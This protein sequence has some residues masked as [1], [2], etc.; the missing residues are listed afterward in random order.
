MPNFRSPL[1]CLLGFVALFCMGLPSLAAPPDA[2][3]WAMYNHDVAGWR[4]NAAEKSLSP[5]NVGGLVEKWRFPA[6]GSRQLVG[7]I[8]ATPSVVNGC[9]YFGTATE[10]TFYKLGP[11]GRLKWSYR[12]PEYPPIKADD[13]G[14]TANGVVDKLKFRGS[15]QAIMTSALVTEDAVYFGDLGGWIYSLD[16]DTGAERWKVNTR[17]ENF[18]GAHP[19]NWIF[20]SPILAGGKIV[21]GGGALEQLIAGTPFYK[22][23]NGRGFVVALDPADGRVVW[24]YD[25]GPKPEKLDPP[26]VIKDSWGEHTFYYGPGTSSI[27][28]SP[29]FDAESGTIYF[30]SDVNT[31]PRRPTD[32]NP[33][34]HTRESCAVIALDVRTGAERWVTQINPGDVWT[35]SMRSYSPEEG[36]YKDQSIGDTPKV[37]TINLAGQPTKVVGAGCK[38]GG[39]YIFRADNGELI[40]HTPLYTGPPSYPLTPTPDPR[41]LALPSAI[42]GLQTGCASD[43]ATIFTNGIDTIRLGSQATPAASGTPPTGG[44]VT[45]ISAD[46]SAEHWRH[47]RPQVATVGGPAPKPVYKNVGDPVASGIAVANGVAYFTTV[48]SGKLVAVDAKSGTL[49]NEIDL[50]PVWSGP[51]VSRGRVYVGTGNTLF[52]PGDYE[53]FFPKQY[54]GTLRCFGLSGEDEVDKLGADAE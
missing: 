25:V 23:S 40:A 6:E 12:N 36:R 37:L 2:A 52:S 20:A 38:N 5:A 19:L 49:L 46:L 8:H 32:D 50:G 30:G 41:M 1:A 47:E 33:A 48:A 18:P 24:K 3:D 29:S 42:G 15:D 43:G 13:G 10:A 51:S 53:S 35:N 39:F 4:Y 21:L 27:W 45:A 11:D 9:V 17:V 7:V 26:I 22:G 16:R 28:S 14:G 34:L 31:A 44:R 54:V